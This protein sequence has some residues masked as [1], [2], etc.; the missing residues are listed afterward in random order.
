MTVY[1]LTAAQRDALLIIQEWMLRYRCPPSL[2]ELRAELG[3]ASRSGA[4][5]LIAC[6]ERRGYV[7]RY[8]R[9]ARSLLVLTPIPMPP[10]P[11]IVGLFDAP[12]L[13]NQVARHLLPEVVP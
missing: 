4:L 3:L 9:R 11:E 6:L 1:G 5:R 13:A 12:P 8:A 7:R 10:E 2:E